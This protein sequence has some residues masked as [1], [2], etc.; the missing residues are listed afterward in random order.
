M[1]NKSLRKV[2]KAFLSNFSEKGGKF[3]DLAGFIRYNNDGEEILSFGKYKGFTLQEI[4]NENPGY[5]SWINQADFPLYTK[6]V[7][8]NFATKMK[9]EKKFEN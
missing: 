6:N 5:F 8:R 1:P 2:A 7:M 4:W 3:A 9:L